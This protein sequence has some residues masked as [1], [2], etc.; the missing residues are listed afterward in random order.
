M[1]VKNVML[2]KKFHVASI[3]VNR[4]VRDVGLLMLEQE[5]KNVYG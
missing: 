4:L 1:I 2:M 5:M 3:G